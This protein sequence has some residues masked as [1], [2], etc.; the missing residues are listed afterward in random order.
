MNP[1][2]AKDF[3]NTVSKAMNGLTELANQSNEKNIL[4]NSKAL[5]KVSNRNSSI[6]GVGSGRDLSAKK[7]SCCNRPYSRNIGIN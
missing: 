3:L 7:C 1:T 2:Q 5:G 6:H 4:G